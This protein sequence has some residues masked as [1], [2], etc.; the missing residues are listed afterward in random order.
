ILFAA[1]L[2]SLFCCPA[3]AFAQQYRARITQLDRSGFPK[4]RVYVAVMDAK[5]QPLTR[6]LEGELLLYEGSK[7][8][9]RSN[10][11][12]GRVAG[13]VSCVLVMDTSGSMNGP[14]LAAAKQAAQTTVDLAPPH[15]AMALIAFADRA[16]EVCRFGADQQTLRAGIG[17]LSAGGS[18][19]LQD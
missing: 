11:K 18:T 12:G 6:S 2:T 9:A 15:F 3:F 4:V 19:A 16:R 10:L 1:V 14:R 13:P 7:C 8:V 5:G 17:G